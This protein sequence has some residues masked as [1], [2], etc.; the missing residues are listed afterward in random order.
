[1]L[2]QADRFMITI[3]VVPPA[4]PNA[5]PV[6]AKLEAVTVEDVKRYCAEYVT[7]A[8]RSVLTLGPRALDSGALACGEGA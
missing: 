3:E 1:M 4:G 7:N 2:P 8:Q 5:E 6:L